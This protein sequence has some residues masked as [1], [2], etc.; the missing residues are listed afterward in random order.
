VRPFAAPMITA[1]M[2][3]TVINDANFRPDL[4]WIST[5]K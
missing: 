1:V 4:I 3:I 2:G 5:S